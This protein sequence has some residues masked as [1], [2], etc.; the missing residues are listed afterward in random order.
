MGSGGSK[1]TPLQ[2]FLDNWKAATKDDDW[3]FKLRKE[4]LRTLCEVDWPAHGTRWP[5][6]GT[7][8]LQLINPLWRNIVSIHPDQIPYIST[9]KRNT[10]NNPP[11]LQNCRTSLGRGAQEARVCAVK[12]KPVPPVLPE[13]EEEEGGILRPPPPYAPPTAPPPP[14][15]PLP[16]S[17]L[18][19]EAG[20]GGGAGGTPAKQDT[21]DDEKDSEE[22]EVHFRERLKKRNKAGKRWSE[23]DELKVKR[24]VEPWKSEVDVSPHLLDVAMYTPKQT[25]KLQRCWL[26]AWD[27]AKLHEVAQKQ[28]EKASTIAPLRRVYDPPGPPGQDGTIPPRTYTV[29]H[30]P[31]TSSDVCN[32]RN[33]NPSF[34]ENPAKIIKLF[35]GIFQ[36]YNPTYDDVQYLLNSLLT[37]EE[38]R[39]VHTEARA[40]L[41]AQNVNEDLAYPLQTPNW[42]YQE[43]NGQNTLN[44]YRQYVLI[45]MRRASRKPINLVKVR[46]VVQKPEEP[47]G[48]FLERLK[49][50]YR[51]Y[52]PLDPDEGANA[53]IIKAA[54]VGQ[55]AHDIR[56]KVQK[57]EGFMGNTL[58]WMLE[59]AQTTYNQR[60]E[61]AQKQK[62]KYQAKK[63]MAL[64]AGAT[65][66][67]ARGGGRARLGRNQCAICKQDGH[68][69]RECPQA[70]SK[71]RGQGRGNLMNPAAE[72]WVPGRGRGRGQGPPWYPPTPG[73]PAGA[74]SLQEDQY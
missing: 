46:E 30:V 2:C 42:D 3:G 40:H 17:Q 19:E 51:Q 62:E 15:A 36:T 14:G 1:C 54:F 67:G 26:E 25:K 60:D 52:T 57:H 49:E 28:K 71:G 73:G 24:D 64:Q 55:A 29:Q 68:W 41:R 69:K 39:R 22:D 9:W 31:F 63:L 10:E 72:S 33:Q 23:Q 32:W 58:E 16:D 56:K 5:S 53:P 21:S 65:G 66:G 61:E 35:E 13:P 20:A 38:V 43:I 47:P 37:T 27:R 70:N 8:D 12:E 6:E 18:P 74:M 59:I 44:T 7:F 45:G 34:E 11:W 48:A 50:A 4:R